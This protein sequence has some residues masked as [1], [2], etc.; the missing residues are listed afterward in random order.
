MGSRQIGNYRVIEYVG[1]GGFGSVFKAEDVNS[2]GR[3][4]AIKE[5]H[6]KH[7]RSTVIKQ[8]F[9]Q[10]ALAMARLDHPNLPRLYTFGEDNGC[11]YLVMEFVSGSPLN[12]ELEDKGPFTSDRAV[13]I[14]T[15][16]L[17]A[18]G[19]AHKNGVIHRD[20]K[21]DNII[22]V[23]EKDSIVVKVLDFGIAKMVGGENLTMT[24]EGFGT[25]SYMSP[26]RILGRSELDLRTDI[27]SVG[28]ILYEMLT[29]AV[30]FQT[31]STDPALFWA[32]M[33]RLHETE[34][35]PPLTQYGVSAEL[36][37]IIRKAAAKR[38]EDRYSTAEEMLVALRGGQATA[39]LLLFTSPGSADVF[40][41]NIQR[42][43]SDEE[44]GRLLVEGLIPG[45]HNVRVARTGYEPY[46][47]DMVLEAN[48]RTD[49]QVQLPARSTVAIPRFDDAQPDASTSKISTGNDAKTAMLVLESLAAGSSVAFAGGQRVLAGED[50]RATVPLGLGTH[51][52]EVTDPSGGSKRKTVTITDQELGSFKTVAIDPAPGQTGAAPYAQPEPVQ[53]GKWTA[54]PVTPPAAMAVKRSTGKVIAAVISVGIF[55]AL[56]VAA[57]IVIRGPGKARQQQAA[58]D[59]KA[60]ALAP[61]PSQTPE[62]Q[63]SAGLSA[64]AASPAPTPNTNKNA[65]APKDEQKKENPQA[66]LK[67]IEEGTPKPG[68]NPHEASPLLVRP[69]P[70]PT[71]VLTRPIDEA[72]T[73]GGTCLIV[74]VTGPAGNAVPGARVAVTDEPSLYQGMTGPNGRWRR[75]GLTPGHRVMVRVFKGGNMI[76][77]KQDV[78]TAGRN[79]IGVQIQATADPYSESSR[80]GRKPGLWQRQP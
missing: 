8:R 55:A 6:K 80:P 14:I 39:S 62:P 32:E 70:T 24:G 33:R 76:G 68:R 77:A 38:I 58:I 19:Y 46:K 36:E 67:P 9:F 54:A 71:P 25:P 12:E 3:I 26:E 66:A 41:D 22:L 44:R 1:S 5:L 47:I 56:A 74:I 72:D 59:A 65:A 11:Y 31:S 63:P 45:L 17:D 13:P 61:T 4:V 49:L 23:R 75:C 28:I 57:I 48:R 43:T 30:P 27:Y 78:L 40:V 16:V 10:E 34:P 21:P 2:P 53:K 50:G 35:I 29:G 79:F 64:G 60:A 69:T 52:L 20:L 73:E 42:G 37:A 51:E 7:T 15:Q 18:V